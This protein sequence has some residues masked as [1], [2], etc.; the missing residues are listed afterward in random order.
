MAEG[1][2]AE[3]IELERQRATENP[4]RHLPRGENARDERIACGIRRWKKR[5]EQQAQQSG[6]PGG[7][8]H[9]M[10]G[11]DA[12]RRDVRSF[13]EQ[14]DCAHKTAGGQTRNGIRGRGKGEKVGCGRQCADRAGGE[15]QTLADSD[16]AKRGGATAGERWMVADGSARK[17]KAKGSRPERTSG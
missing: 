8:E 6:D 7:G 4:G 17:C 9:R 11:C 13:R 16:G 5:R 14:R 10:D 12:A 3:S 1:E 15:R 2:P